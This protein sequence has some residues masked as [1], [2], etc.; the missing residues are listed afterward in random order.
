VAVDR[1]GR[2]HAGPQILLVVAGEVTAVDSSGQTLTVP[3][4][5]SLWIPASDRG[6]SITGHGTVFRAVDGLTH[7][8]SRTPGAHRQPPQG[9][10]TQ[11][12]PPRTTGGDD[13]TRRSDVK[14]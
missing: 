3:P 9:R 13:V 11:P 4:G 6:G 10:A 2:G 12:D 7:T 8:L 14:R 5:G 1:P